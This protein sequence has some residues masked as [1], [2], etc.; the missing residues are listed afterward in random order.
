MKTSK[1]YNELG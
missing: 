1:Q